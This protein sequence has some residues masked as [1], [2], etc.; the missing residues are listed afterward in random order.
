MLSCGLRQPGWHAFTDWD[1]IV[2]QSFYT[3]VLPKRKPSNQ[4]GSAMAT[5]ENRLRVCRLGFCE[6][7]HKVQGSQQVSMNRRR[8]HRWVGKWRPPAGWRKRTQ[9]WQNCVRSV[10]E[11]GFFE[12]ILSTLK[13]KKTFYYVIK[14]TSLTSLH[15]PN[16]HPICTNSQKRKRARSFKTYSTVRKHTPL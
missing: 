15:L 10:Y 7:H 8:R 4:T 5:Q 9:G 12:Y 2:Q 3:G 13:R 6:D 16:L 11:R 1:P 14:S